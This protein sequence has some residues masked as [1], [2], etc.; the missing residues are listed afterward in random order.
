MI[1]TCQVADRFYSIPTSLVHQGK[2]SRE[3]QINAR[4]NSNNRFDAEQRMENPRSF[5]VSDQDP[6]E[7]N[8]QSD[9]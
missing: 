5:T 8:K 9:T 1:A 3:Y 6:G 7:S 4:C 2:D